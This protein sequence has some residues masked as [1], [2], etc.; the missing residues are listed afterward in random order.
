VT[1]DNANIVENEEVEATRGRM[2]H[3]KMSKNHMP[4]MNFLFIY[5]ERR[6]NFIS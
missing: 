5:I 1:S 4:K 2:S 6:E 3:R